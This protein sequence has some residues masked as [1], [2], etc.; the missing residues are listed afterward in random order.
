MRLVAGVL[1]L[2]LL[3]AVQLAEDIATV[4]TLCGGRLIVG[5]GTGY[6]Q[7]E[8]D[9][10]GVDMAQRRRRGLRALDEMVAWWRGEPVRDTGAT[11]G[12]RPVSS[13]HPPIWLA[14][15]GP[16]TYREALERGD[17][18]F[19]GA[20]VSMNKLAGL[21][22]SAPGPKAVALRRDVLVTDVVDDSAVAAAVKLRTEQY[23]D[24]GYGLSDESPYLIGSVADCRK[25]I[26]GLEA[27]GVTDVVI[28]TNWPAVS[29]AASREM[30]VALANA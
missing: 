25:H 21:L 11:L 19:I 12:L 20:Q 5:V 29:A 28:R 16:R 27:L 22:R 30:L 15:G 10:F 14:V 3:N 9:A 24:W 23:G 1:V 8:F 13:P 2:P 18:P 7:V 17:T 4:D 26:A 6:R